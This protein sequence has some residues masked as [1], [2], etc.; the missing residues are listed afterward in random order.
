MKLMNAVRQR[1]YSNEQRVRVPQDKWSKD[2]LPK[3]ELHTTA[4]CFILSNRIC[5]EPYLS[6][7]VH[8]VCASEKVIKLRVNMLLM[9]QVE[10]YH[11]LHQ[12]KRAPL[13]ST[14]VLNNDKAV[15]DLRLTLRP[16]SVFSYWRRMCKETPMATQTTEFKQIWDKQLA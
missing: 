11:K 14:F 3:N 16:L 7:Y 1:S 12:D 9:S 4:K 8:D 13:T 5:L 10:S 6:R 15:L 2:V